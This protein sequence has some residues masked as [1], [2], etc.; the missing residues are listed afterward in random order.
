MTVPLSPSSPIYFTPDHGSRSGPNPNPNP[1][2]SPNP[3]PR[4]PSLPSPAQGRG[5]TLTLTLILALTLTLYTPHSL[6][7]LNPNPNQVDSVTF[8]STGTPT[9][10][11]SP[12]ARGI[13]RYH[14]ALL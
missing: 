9:P 12:A 4:Y 3:N 5:L 6:R 13:F 14:S 1:N 2:P 8:P 11:S 7:R 10:P